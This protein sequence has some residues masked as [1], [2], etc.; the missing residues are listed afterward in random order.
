MMAARTYHLMTL[1]ECAMHSIP[2]RLIAV[3]SVV[4]VVLFSA[5]VAYAETITQPTGSPFAVPG[6][7]S[8]N[9][10]PF[11]VV[12]TGFPP[13][14]QVYVETCDGVPST[15]TN[16]DPTIDC[17]NGAS[18]A[19]VISSSTGVATFTAPGNRQFVPVKGLQP[20]G[21]FACDAPGGPATTPAPTLGD[22]TNCQLRVSTS[23]T[24]PTTDQ[25]FLTLTMPSAP[26]VTTTTSTTTTTTTTST[27]TTTVPSTGS[28]NLTTCSGFDF[29]GTIV[30]PLAGSG[31]VTTTVAQMKSAKAGTVVWGPGFGSS[32]TIP[33]APGTVEQG[34]CAGPM[35]NDS[36]MTV[37]AKLSGAAT[38]ITGSTAAGQ[39][40]LN[41]KLALANVAKTVKEQAYVRVAGFDTS[42]GPDIISIT[43]TDVKGLMPGA[44]VSG[45]VGFDPVVKALVNGQGGGPELKNQYYFDNAQ[46]TAACGSGPTGTSIGLIFGTDGTTLLGS[47]GQPISFD[48]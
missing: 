12:A 8:G 32:I 14:T 43:G 34:A 18:N 38:C 19:P 25:V 1:E 36:T 11:T 35:L 46:L 16:W 41:G 47:S 10:V 48:I 21:L 39:Y 9:P 27:T 13:S 45:E 17:D 33:G 37:G 29:F 3:A 42:A 4:S 40:P 7:A 30:P 24:G 2:R 20:T 22:W 15:A 31:A 44:S 26:V 5:G 28:T 6:D 23:N